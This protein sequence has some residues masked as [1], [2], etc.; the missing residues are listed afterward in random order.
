MR[1]RKEGKAIKISYAGQGYSQNPQEFIAD[2]RKVGTFWEN[3]SQSH[4]QILFL[5]SR[6]HF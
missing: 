5:F 1:G 6:S 3:K 2:I 4:S